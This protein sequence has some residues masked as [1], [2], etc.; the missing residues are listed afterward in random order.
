MKWW[1]ANCHSKDCHPASGGFNSQRERAATLA[2]YS[3]EAPAEL[4]RIV[5]KALRKNREE[6]YQ[7]IKDLQLDLKSLKQELELE[8]ELERSILPKSR[9]R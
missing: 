9:V 4:E 7:T 2:R 8:G 1:L 3:R 6:R 5:S